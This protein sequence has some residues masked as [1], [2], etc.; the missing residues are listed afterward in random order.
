MI[1]LNS[2]LHSEHTQ[3]RVGVLLE[4]F[5]R[6]ETTSG[7]DAVIEQHLHERA[8]DEVVHDH[9]YRQGRCKRRGIASEKI[10]R[11]GEERC[12]DGPGNRRRGEDAERG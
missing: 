6:V 9:R 3:E 10:A 12:G 11:I 4:M 5:E 8:D 1:V 7:R 2:T